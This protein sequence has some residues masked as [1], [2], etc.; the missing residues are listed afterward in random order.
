M[1]DAHQ[2]YFVIGSDV[3]G[4]MG[5][6]LIPLETLDD[7]KEFK[8]DH[9]GKKILRFNQIDAELTEKLDSGTFD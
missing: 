8:A 2:A 9:Q 1:I 6:E 5:H 4:P 7:A 3:L